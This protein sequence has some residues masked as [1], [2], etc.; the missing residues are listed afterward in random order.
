MWFRNLQIYR[1]DNPF[2]LSAEGLHEQLQQRESRACGALELSTLGWTSPLGRHGS[3]LTHAVGN[4]IMFCARR[5]EKV[6]PNVVV[7]EILAERVADLEES[8]ARKVRRREQAEM[9]EQLMLELL[10]QAFTKSALSYA[11]I[12]V[13]NGW[14][15]VDAASA[16]RAEDLITLLRETLGS[17]PVRPL[18]VVESPSAVMT[19]WLQ[20]EQPPQEFEIQDEC[21][22]RDP[23][24][25]GG[26]VRC[27]RQDLAGDEIQAHLKAGKRVVQLALEW[28]ERIGLLLTEALDIKRL[29]F[30]DQVLEEAADSEAESFA[31]RFD[32]DF[33]LMS[34]ELGRFI[35]RLLA[36]FGGVDEAA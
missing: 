18:Q 9:K 36:L 19:S 12:D 30:L 3:Q 33:A 6:L 22:L 23:V 17:F 25:E 4:C 31:D 20:G 13:A 5:E 27:R 15:L 14:L 1:L 10:P 24:E 2:E 28:H 35:P 7:R 21:E 26:I 32:V 34:G 29:R 11:Y 16:K 8:E